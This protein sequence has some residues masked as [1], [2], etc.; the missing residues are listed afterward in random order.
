MLSISRIRFETHAHL[1]KQMISLPWISYI[2]EKHP[3]RFLPLKMLNI[4]MELHLCQK[5]KKIMDICVK[6]NTTFTFPILSTMFSRIA[7]TKYLLNQNFYPLPKLIFFE[8]H[9]PLCSLGSK[10]QFITILRVLTSC[11]I[12][13]KP[14]SNL[15]GQRN[16]MYWD[17]N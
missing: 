1:I 14:V 10:K 13:N 15:Y 17:T 6:I 7:K 8:N 11:A 3:C 9:I 5:K 12:P 4:I 16:H 2:K